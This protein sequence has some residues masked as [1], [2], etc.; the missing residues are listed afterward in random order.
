MTVDVHRAG[1]TGDMGGQGFNVDGQSGG[2]AAEALGPNAQGIDFL[3]QLLLQSGIEGLGVVGAHLPQ[4]GLLGQQGALVKGAA[5]AHPHHD[6]R[7]GVG[8]GLLHRVQN[9]GFDPFQPVGGLEHGD[10]AHVFAAKALGGHGDLHPV[11]GHQRGVQH[12]GGV[13]TGI[14]PV[15]RVGHHRLAEI[16]LGVAPAHPFVHRLG[17]VAVNM[18]LLAHLQKDAG[19]AGVLADGDISADGVIFHNFIQDVLGHRPGLRLTGGGDGVLHILRQAG[20]GRDAQ[21]GNRLR[22][23]AG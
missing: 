9:K 10:A 6:G 12:G 23:R 2:P 16:A 13:V 21:P 14:H 15:Q 3:Q 19:H 20:V 18:D 22:D 4:Q 8:T 1:Q 17:Q 11:P 7:T 5:D